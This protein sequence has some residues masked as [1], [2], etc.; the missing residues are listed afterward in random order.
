M[1]NLTPKET[2]EQL[3]DNY[4]NELNQIDSLLLLSQKTFTAKQC[5]LICVDEIINTDALLNESDAEC[6]EGYK[7]T[8]RIEYWEEV[9][10]EIQLL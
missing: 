1:K 8:I 5:A 7:D 2:A 10:K 4:L 6:I 3:V 9:K